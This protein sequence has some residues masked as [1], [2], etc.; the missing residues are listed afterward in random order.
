MNKAVGH[1]N[2]FDLIRLFAAS[3]VFLHHLYII[4]GVDLG[5][6][7]NAI[8]RFMV[9]FPGVPIFFFI[10]GYLISQSFEN[11]RGIKSYSI[12]R[13]LRIY[14]A[15]FASVM[16]GVV[17][18]IINGYESGQLVGLLDWGILIFTKITIFQFYNPDF[19]RSYGDGV[20]NGNLWTIT[21]ELQFYIMI[22]L[23]YL[24]QRR[25]AIKK[26]TFWLTILVVSFLF[27]R[28]HIFLFPHYKE[29]IWFKLYTVSF[30]PWLYM[31]V[32]GIMARQHK[33]FLIYYVKKYAALIISGYI[34]IAYTALHFSLLEFGNH[35]SPL[36]V[37]LLFLT[38]LCFAHCYPFL[39]QKL[40]K[41]QDVSYG[42]YLYHMLVIN[43][44]LYRYGDGA[45]E[46]TLPIVVIVIII[47]MAS[48]F[49]LEKHALKLKKRFA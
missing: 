14:P 12:K 44:F 15:L 6:V 22:I 23:L 27:N 42:I 47:S 1:H 29:E 10:S 36:L 46:K 8:S 33:Q 16:L 3:E 48:W 40:L 38:I 31:F 20:F 9:L 32:L 19:L 25:F 17:L 35:I 26:L 21:V 18:I 5:T 34:I 43:F 45:A 37:P 7:I 13:V 39:A 49:L 11:S 30:A 28:L 24:V 41:G 2:N 4:V